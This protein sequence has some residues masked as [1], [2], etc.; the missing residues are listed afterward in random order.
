MATF[1]V[2]VIIHG[3]ILL[4]GHV[5]IGYVGLG[6]DSWV[7]KISGVILNSAGRGTALFIYASLL[8]TSLRFVAG[9][10]V[11]KI[12]L[13]GLFVRECDH[14]CDRLVLR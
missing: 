7:K 11:H 8:M 6:T 13:L 2:S 9:P 4:I 5:C 1:L 3:M 10:I 14:W 12:L